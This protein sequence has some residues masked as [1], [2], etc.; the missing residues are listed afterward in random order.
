MKSARIEP[1]PTGAPPRPRVP[2]RGNMPVDD[3]E[4]KTGTQRTIEPSS[5][6]GVAWAV[7]GR[8]AAAFE[9]LPHV[10]VIAWHGAD[11]VLN[12]PARR[13]LGLVPGD[14]VR[15]VDE[16]HSLLRPSPGDGPHDG[17]PRAPMPAEEAPL[18]RALSGDTVRGQVLRV[19]G[20]D[21]APRTWSVDASPIFEGDDVLGAVCVCRDVTEQGLDES[22]ADD[23]L[24]R[25]AHDLR[26]PLTALKASAQL[27]ARG[28]ERLDE[29]ARSR[30]LSL[31][32]AQVDKLSAR[33]DDVLDAARI[34]RGRWDLSPEDLDLAS[35]LRDIARELD[36]TPTAPRCTV[37]APEGVR[38]RGDRMRLRQV[39]GQLVLEAAE[40]HGPHA[41]VAMRAR[42]IDGRV[43][44]ALELPGD[45]PKSPPA[46][47][48]RD[49]AR[50]L[51]AAV[52]DRLGGRTQL[53]D[54]GARGI[55]LTLPLASD[56][57]PLAGG[58]E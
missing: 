31:L 50:R 40:R 24:G 28:W 53:D 16:L 8:I 44:I 3:D 51:A 13:A 32:L 18:A 9:A 1:T 29:A 23:L 6:A 47:R 58:P 27:L 26:T 39:I 22:M 57:S 54:G 48:R 25:A 38:V 37:E 4:P 30:T 14:R 36:A 12:E 45:P 5:P 11:L 20:H 55:V 43:D 33:V 46:Q 21:D 19:H 41:A 49:T 42:P 34:R 35:T 52:F 2:Q 17:A 56:A 10:V 15:T 7:P